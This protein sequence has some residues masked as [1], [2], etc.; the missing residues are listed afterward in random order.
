MP[1][2]EIAIYEHNPSGLVYRCLEDGLEIT[3][4]GDFGKV[5]GE[6]FEKFIEE[7]RHLRQPLRD[8]TDVLAEI[9]N[10]VPIFC[11]RDV[12]HELSPG[13]FQ[14]ILDKLAS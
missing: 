10:K 5:S 4:K 1:K 13:D 11:R 14:L 3:S 8:R 7:I 12:C 2:Y 6:L 9:V